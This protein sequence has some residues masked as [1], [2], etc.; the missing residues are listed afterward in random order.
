MSAK[1]HITRESWTNVFFHM[2][3][4]N[5]TEIDALINTDVVEFFYIYKAFQQKIEKENKVIKRK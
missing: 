2:G 3:N 4:G 1:E 5:K